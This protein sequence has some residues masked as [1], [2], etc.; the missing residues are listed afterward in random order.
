MNRILRRLVQVVAVLGTVVVGLVAVALIVSQT[1]WFRDWLRGY[2]VRQANQVLEGELSI[3]RV[4]GNLLY[5]L[6]LTDVAVDFERQRVI[7][8][9]E[10]TVQY[11]FIDFIARGIVIERLEVS[12]PSIL[13]HRTAEGWNL[14]RLVREEEREEERE[15]PARP[16]SLGAV[17]IV[18]GRLRIVDEIGMDAVEVPARVE[19]VNARFSFEYEPVHYTIELDHLSLST[20]DPAF[21]LQELAG[22]I[23][24]RDDALHVSDLSMRTAESALHVE[25]IVEQYSTAPVLRLGATGDRL[26]LPEFG[27]L[28]PALREYELRPA[29]RV[30]ANGPLEALRLGLDVDAQ[31]AGRIQGQVTADV[32]APTYGVRGDLELADLNLAP[33]LADPEQQ[34]DI[35]GRARVD[36][37]F[38]AADPLQ[39]LRG[40]YQFAGPHA[41]FGGFEAANVEASGRF[42][43][44]QMTLDARAEAYD[45]TATATGTITLPGEERLLAYDLRGRTADLDLRNLPPQLELPRF[46]TDLNLAYHVVG[47][48]DV[49]RGDV[50]L[51]RSRL[52][53]ATI[54]PATT[55]EFAV[56]PQR[57][58]YGAAGHITN[59]DVQRIGRI[60]QIEALA[61][62]MFRSDVSGQFSVR[63]S[64]T[65]LPRLT[66]EAEGVLTDSSILHAHLPQMAFTARI[67]HGTL[68]VTSRGEF[69]GIDPAVVTDRDEMR[70][71]LSGSVDAAITLRDMGEDFDLEQFGFDGRLVLAGSS[72]AGF[73]IERGEVDATFD[74]GVAQVR[75]LDLAGLDLTVTAAGTLALDRVSASD[76][77]Y[78]VI[79][80]DLAAVG[81]FVEQPLGGSASIEGRVEGNA[82]ALRTSGQLSGS[83][84]RFD[85]H[86]ALTLD[87]QYDVTL[88]DLDFAQAHVQADTHATFMEVAGQEINELTAR[89]TYAAQELE[90]EASIAQEA[91]EVEAGGRLVLHTDHQEI[92]LPRLRVATAGAGWRMAPEGDPRIDYGAEVLEIRDIRL[93]S[94]AQEIR[95]D[96]TLGLAPETTGALEVV[97]SNVEMAYLEELLLLDRG[98]GGRL[99]AAATVRGSTADLQVEARAT[100]DQGTVEEFRFQRLA[101]D[102][103]YDG[104]TI[105]VDARLDQAPQAWFTA[106]GVIPMTMF[107]PDPEAPGVHIPPTPEDRVDLRIQSSPIDLAIVQGFTDQLTDVTGM[108]QLDVHV[109]GSG[110]DPH[111][112]GVLDIR[113][114]AFG[115]EATG[116]Q[117]TGLDTRIDFQPDRAV[118][119]EFSIRDQRRQTLT[120]AGELA[121]HAR[122]IGEVDVGIHTDRFTAL[123]NPFGEVEVGAALRI[124]G[125]LLRPRIV[126]DVHVFSGR[127]EVDQVLEAVATEPYA[128]EDVDPVLRRAAGPAGAPGMLAPDAPPPPE[129]RPAVDPVE[130][131]GPDEPQPAL[132]DALAL[133]MRLTIPNNLVLRGTDL[134][135]GGVPV[136]L[137]NMN[138][139]VGGD[140]RILKD[141]GEAMRLMGTVRTVRGFYDFQGRRF[142]ILRDGVIRFEGL[143]EIDPAL[144]IRAQRLIAGVE[145]EIRLAGTVS[146]PELSLSSSPPLDDADILSLIV[147]NQPLN[148]LGEGE[149]IS[150]AQRAGALAT[151]FVVG[152]LAE[153]IGQALNV[154]LFEIQAAADGARVVV[155]EQVGDRLFVRFSQQFGAQDVSEFILEYQLADF[156]RL[157]T[158]IAE[159]GGRAVGGLTRRVERGGVDLIFFFSY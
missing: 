91:R 35:T 159:G 58:A 70:G 47:R 83:S 42:D 63:G 80:T 51:D 111:F 81:E 40:T 137:G 146:Q 65:D 110:R 79:V 133:D 48:G 115:L 123:S 72:V 55:A 9:P 152:P 92:H 140:L 1:P 157:Q 16:I 147:F 17:V 12:G 117:Y 76:L 149:R 37:R 64:G 130:P 141:A 96:G 8:I 41:A 154:D 136:G 53:G 155:G 145:A 68:H 156:L 36:L 89:T 34:S 56:E 3:G 158:S 142:T 6:E 22:H 124:T 119:Q 7:E 78:R 4:G 113:G 39:N 45:G 128:I 138:I 105:E 99:D 90:F 71:Q 24:V 50:R 109:T 62:E 122:Q 93:V 125:E 59:L 101:A 27:R 2:V 134:R 144:D 116:V 19:P 97:L 10:V 86:S 85:G 88:L 77:E 20:H 143:E 104:R 106:Q 21:V 60:L 73:Q 103:A 69:V 44:P 94:G 84:L 120:V 87:S 150:L 135:V 139:T 153:S 67:D 5:G 108:V 126:G 28:L 118:I 23:S 129:V 52:E 151:G 75:E 14:G 102:L 26:S 25:G 112:E 33:L 132:F 131:V 121:T 61:D 148:Q 32:T 29:F 38:P 43:G 98:L 31:E 114:G 57:I 13:L 107:E 74:G 100:I 127:I 66:L 49:I 95:A 11:N 46:Q 30:D 15:G 54:A 18:D 82:A